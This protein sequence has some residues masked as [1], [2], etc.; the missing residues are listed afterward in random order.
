MLVITQTS[1]R[2]A[3]KPNQPG[4][5]LER[6]PKE[7]IGL[8]VLHGSSW[9]KKRTKTFVS[10]PITPLHHGSSA[11]LFEACKVILRH[12]VLHGPVHLLNRQ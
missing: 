5:A 12:C 4:S 7:L 11:V 10:S 6:D 8:L 9:R 2:M 3:T 1:S